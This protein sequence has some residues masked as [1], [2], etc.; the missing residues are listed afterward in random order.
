MV[1]SA[2]NFSGMKG[3]EEII[4]RRTTQWIKQ[5]KGR[6]EGGNDFDFSPWA[7][8]LTLDIIG[9]VAFGTDLGCVEKGC[10]T[11]GLSSGFRAG[12]LAFGFVTR[13]HVAAEWVNWS[14]I[15]R[16]LEWQVPRDNTIG[17]LMRFG[18]K[19]VRERLKEVGNPKMDKRNDMLQKYVLCL[20][21]LGCVLG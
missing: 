19:A 14:W 15:G 6:F 21:G 20:C 11:E 1:A 10:D 13:M 4:D 7:T 3:L 8:F 17:V 2:Y 5:L 18:R 16:F 9:E 12:L